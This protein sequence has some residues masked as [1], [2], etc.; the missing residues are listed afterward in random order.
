M[1]RIGVV[2][3][4]RGMIFDKNAFFVDF[5]SCLMIVENISRMSNH[6]GYLARR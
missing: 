1:K 2:V 5:S 3:I 6:S 4:I